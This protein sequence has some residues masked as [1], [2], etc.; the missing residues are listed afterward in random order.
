MHCIQCM[1]I[2][3][4]FLIQVSPEAKETNNDTEEIAEV[5]VK[6]EPVSRSECPSDHKAQD[7]LEVTQGTSEVSHKEDYI[8]VVSE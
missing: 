5:D 4:L 8:P 6:D 1:L 7:S 3:K 2:F